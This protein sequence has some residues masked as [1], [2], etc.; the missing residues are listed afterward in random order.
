MLGLKG[1]TAV[2]AFYF[3]LFCI[4]AFSLVPLAFRLFLNLQVKIGH[5]EVSLIKWLQAHEMKKPFLQEDRIVS[6][7]GSI[8]GDE[9]ADTIY[10][11]PV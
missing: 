10:F 2:L 8:M 9:H 3:A 5:R 11:C 7:S 1:A 4:M 6:M